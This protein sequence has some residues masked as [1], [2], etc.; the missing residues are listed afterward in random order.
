MKWLDRNEGMILKILSVIFLGFGTGLLFNNEYGKAIE[1][2]AI[3]ILLYGSHLLSL[4]L[5]KY[6]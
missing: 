1:S 3:G 6:F 5:E 4:K 2:G